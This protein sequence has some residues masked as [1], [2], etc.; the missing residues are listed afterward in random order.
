MWPASPA[1]SGRRSDDPLRVPRIRPPDWHRLPADRQL[2]CA[3]F[4]SPDG[5]AYFGARCG[6]RRS[7]ISRGSSRWPPSGTA[8]VSP[9]GGDRVPPT[10][11]S[12]RARRHGG[13]PSLSPAGVGVASGP[14]GVLKPARGWREARL[15]KAGGSSSPTW[16]HSGVAGPYTPR[17]RGRQCRSG[18]SSRCS[19]VNGRGPATTSCHRSPGRRCPVLGNDG[20]EGDG[21]D[22]A[23]PGLS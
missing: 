17:D 18:L 8:R 20:T 7:S 15:C 10:P 6:A 1:S 13:E 11:P 14:S 12:G 19:N 22:R 21:D 23:V 4:R 9:G 3:P 5:Q 2:A 16:A